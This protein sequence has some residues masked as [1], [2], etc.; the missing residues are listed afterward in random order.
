[1]PVDEHTRIADG[2]GEVLDTPD[3]T[4]LGRLKESVAEQNRIRK[5]LQT[6]VDTQLRDGVHYWRPK[7][8]DRRDDDRGPKRKPSL[9]K[10]GA[11]SF[12]DLFKAWPRPHDA[13]RVLTDDGHLDVYYRCD[14]VAMGG[15]SLF[16][17]HAGDVVATGDGFCSTREDKYGYRWVFESE[18]A[19][20]LDKEALPK[21]SWTKG[22]R[23]FTKFR[24]ANPDVAS[25]YNTVLKMADK[26]ALV[27]AVLK[28]PFVSELFTQDLEDGGTGDDEQG[29]GERSGPVAS[30]AARP[31]A[32]AAAPASPAPAE[33]G[34]VAAPSTAAAPPA[35]PPPAAPPAPA[36][37][38]PMSELEK[39]VA[40]MREMTQALGWPDQQLRAFARSLVKGKRLEEYMLEDVQVVSQ[41]LQDVL[42]SKERRSREQVR[43]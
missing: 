20:S 36:E 38:K 31:A 6:Y 5:E 32:G 16:G 22:D 8:D 34:A 26:R 12:C 15:G 28:L 25:T 43:P 42:R 35:A 30:E 17:W 14:V 37:P 18:L 24:I 4:A 40:H 39:A 7:R 10:E 3:E 9:T 2:T 23:R 1:M 41:E 27:C 29:R 21:R 33:S 19:G 13:E 11:L